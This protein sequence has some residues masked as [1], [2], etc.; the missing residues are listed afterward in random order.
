M[1][2]FVYE[3]QGGVIVYNLL[4]KQKLMMLLSQIV[5]VCNDC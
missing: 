3:L 2:I 1:F 5:F 4:T